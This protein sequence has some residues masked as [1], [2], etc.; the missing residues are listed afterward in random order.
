MTQIKRAHGVPVVQNCSV[1]N[2]IKCLKTNRFP[3]YCVHAWKEG[4][5][6]FPLGLFSTPAIVSGFYHWT[7]PQPCCSPL[8]SLSSRSYW[9]SSKPMPT[10]SVKARGTTVNIRSK[11]SQIPITC[12]ASWALSMAWSDL[13]GGPWCPESLFWR[14]WFRML[15]PALK[16]PES[17]DGCRYG[18]CTEVPWMYPL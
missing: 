9:D 8:H 3:S 2:D 17:C 1:T 4:G 11:L 16:Q 13:W 7:T 18:L 10:I 6:S 15:P 14:A 12:L 5:M